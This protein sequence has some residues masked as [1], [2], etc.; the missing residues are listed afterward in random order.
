MLGIVCYDNEP[1]SEGISIISIGM[2]TS[3]DLWS[4]RTPLSM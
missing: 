4:V 3:L 1:L 2:H